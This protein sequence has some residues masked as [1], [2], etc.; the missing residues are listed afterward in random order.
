MDMIDSEHVSAPGSGHSG[1]FKSRLWHSPFFPSAKSLVD[2]PT[3][4]TQHS[5]RF[6]FKSRFHRQLNGT[7]DTGEN[8]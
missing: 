4:T 6:R 5:S 7:P 2:T 3:G 8:Q 1:S